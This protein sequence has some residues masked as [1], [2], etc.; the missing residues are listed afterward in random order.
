MLTKLI[1][2]GFKG[3]RI[4]LGQAQSIP[5]ADGIRVPGEI[6]GV[7]LL[8]VYKSRPQVIIGDIVCRNGLRHHLTGQEC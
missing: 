3:W 2:Q 5:A 4:Y 7:G 1:A 6:K 8:A